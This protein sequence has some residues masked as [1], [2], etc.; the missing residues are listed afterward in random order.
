MN[1]VICG[2]LKKK[3]KFYFSFDEKTVKTIINRVF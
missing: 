3:N 2:I 1:N